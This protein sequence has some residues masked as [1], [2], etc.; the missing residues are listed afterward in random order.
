MIL[1]TLGHRYT[2]VDRLDP[3]VRTVCAIA[4]ALFPL[5]LSDLRVLLVTLGVVLAF[6]LY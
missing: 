1:E 4:A 3:R 5:F 2:I 6:V